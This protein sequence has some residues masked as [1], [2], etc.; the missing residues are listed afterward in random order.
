[1][2]WLEEPESGFQHNHSVKQG[3]ELIPSAALTL[4]GIRKAVHGL[5]PDSLPPLCSCGPKRS[6]GQTTLLVSRTRYIPASP[7]WCL[8]S[9]PGSEYVTDCKLPSVSWLGPGVAVPGHCHNLGSDPCL[10]NEMKKRQLKQPKNG[11][12]SEK[13]Q[14]EESHR[15]EP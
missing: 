13:S 5:T 3:L 12:W 9:S 10:T 2:Y 6:S 14:E 1:M 11:K 7:E 15:E 4:G 8:G